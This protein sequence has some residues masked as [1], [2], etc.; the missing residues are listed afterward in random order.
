MRQKTTHKIVKPAGNSDDF[1][2]PVPQEFDLPVTALGV[3]Q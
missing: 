3:P 2:K 1:S